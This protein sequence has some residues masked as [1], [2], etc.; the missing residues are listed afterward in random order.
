MRTK[1][2]K[3]MLKHIVQF[4]NALLNHPEIRCRSVDERVIDRNKAKI[5]SLKK[6]AK[7]L[8]NLDGDENDIAYSAT[9]ETAMF[10]EFADFVEKYNIAIFRTEAVVFEWDGASHY[11]T[12]D[13]TVER[14]RAI[15][16]ACST[17]GFKVLKKIR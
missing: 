7:K 8:G 5:E 10:E 6:Y 9:D 2:H 17:F 16:K 14:Y 3:V 11:I 15:C 12:D 4:I 1:H 13:E